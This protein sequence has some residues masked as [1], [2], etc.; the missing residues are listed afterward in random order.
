MMNHYADTR[1]D[2][3]LVALVLAGERETYAPLLLRYY[4]R[5]F[6]YPTDL[7]ESFPKPTKLGALNFPPTTLGDS[8]Q[9]LKTA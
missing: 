2:A 6:L 4:P 1:S 7:L 9:P 3:T 5:I 8:R